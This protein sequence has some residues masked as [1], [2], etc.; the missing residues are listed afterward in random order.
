VRL[1][2]KSAEAEAGCA[3]LGDDE[4]SVFE[5]EFAGL[6]SVLFGA[7]AGFPV[8]RMAGS[9]FARVH[10]RSYYGIPSKCRW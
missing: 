3:G 7:D 1:P 4:A 5:Q 10:T 6:A 8:D 2:F 9:G